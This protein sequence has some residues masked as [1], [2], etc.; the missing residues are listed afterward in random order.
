MGLE[1]C[2][3]VLNIFFKSF[4]PADELFENLHFLGCNLVRYTCAT[5]R[6]APYL[7]VPVVEATLQLFPDL[8]RVNQTTTIRSSGVSQD[9][10]EH[11]EL[12][13]FSACPSESYPIISAI[14]WW[15]SIFSPHSVSASAKPSGA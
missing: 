9:L 12:I 10:V 15:I 5:A 13:V 11:R 2:T 7:T 14:I 1:R 6:T 8:V 3:T 4:N